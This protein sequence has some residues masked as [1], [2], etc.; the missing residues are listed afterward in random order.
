MPVRIPSDQH[1]TV[2]SVLREAARVNGDVEAYVEPD[3]RGG[4]RS[5]TFAAVGPRRGRRRRPPGPPRRGQGRRRL[6]APALV[7]RLRRAVRGAAPPGCHHVGHQPAHGGT[8][9][10]LPSSTGPRRSSWWSTPRSGPAPDAGTGAGGHPRRGPDVVGRG[11]AG[12]MAGA[13][14]VRPGGRGLDERD[15]GRAQG[16]GLR[17]RQPGRGGPGHRRAEPSG[18]PPALPAALRPRR[19]T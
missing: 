8:A 1:E 12:R 18:R 16:R 5:L 2:V 15:D 6:P 10:W 9:R 19:A 3:G 17:S 11:G 7:H 4:R 13:G 14:L